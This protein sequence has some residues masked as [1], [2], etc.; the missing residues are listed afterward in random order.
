MQ[1]LAKAEGF[2]EQIERIKDY[3]VT[4][5]L[6]GGGGGMN[7]GRKMKKICSVS[8]LPS[9][10]ISPRRKQPLQCSDQANIQDMPSPRGFLLSFLIPFLSYYHQECV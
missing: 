8:Y 7:K 5:E 3:E 6:D 4:R 2:A 10:V 9:S 1:A